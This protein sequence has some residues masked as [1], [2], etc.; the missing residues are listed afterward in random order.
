MGKEVWKRGGRR[1]CG[2]NIGENNKKGN[3]FLKKIQL[4]SYFIKEDLQIVR[5]NILKNIFIT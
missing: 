2:R 1:N 5:I 4:I 3:I